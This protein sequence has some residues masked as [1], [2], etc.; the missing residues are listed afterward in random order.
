MIS[1]ERAM[2]CKI[3]EHVSEIYC[4]TNVMFI[5]IMC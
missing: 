5:L 4:N 2:K 1:G 3:N